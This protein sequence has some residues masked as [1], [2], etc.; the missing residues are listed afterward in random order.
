M[1]LNYFSTITD[2]AKCRLKKDCRTGPS[3]KVANTQVHMQPVCV[4]RPAVSRAA[5][6]M[7]Q[8]SIEKILFQRHEC[9]ES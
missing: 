8:C 2:A 5:S 1:Q 4:S 3:S 9:G 6:G 7:P